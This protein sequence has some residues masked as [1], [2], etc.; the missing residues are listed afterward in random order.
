MNEKRQ[1]LNKKEILKNL[2]NLNKESLIDL[3]I[4]EVIGSTNDEARKKLNKVQ[5][6]EE[7][8]AIFAETIE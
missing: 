5:N 8:F 2:S 4:F 7:S 6:L 1:L 3:T